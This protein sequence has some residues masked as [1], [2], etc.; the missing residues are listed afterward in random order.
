VKCGVLALDYDG[1]IAVD[2]ALDP[3]VRAAIAEVRAAGVAVVLV[4][5][6]IL[7]D[8]R[9]LTGDLRFVDAV[10]AENGAVVVYP[11]TGHS[12]VLGSPPPV[13]F[14][15]HIRQHEI[16]IAV[17]TCVVEASA[18]DAHRVLSVVREM[19]LPLVL[20]FNRSRLMILP[21][22]VGKAAG[23][24]EVLAGL[25]LSPHTAIAIGD[26]ENDHRMLEVCEIGV[27]VGWGS[28]ALQALADE[29][30]DARPARDDASRE[31]GRAPAAERSLALDQRRV[32]RLFSCRTGLEARGTIP[33]WAVDVNDR[34]MEMI[35]ERYELTD[36]RSRHRHEKQ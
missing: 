31:R 33:D 27:A 35:R 22:T 26:A 17:G 13:P 19:E 29:V 8:L 21:E 30:L 24:R 6:R 10:V 1:T 16:E 5:G 4:T 25:R 12:M 23:L 36:A 2:G 7:D 18:S 20:L 32:W 11:M 9:R 15:D 28:R 3:H 14:V 34:L